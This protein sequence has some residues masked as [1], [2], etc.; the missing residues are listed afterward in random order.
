MQNTTNSS[1]EKL[2]KIL[3]H[4]GYVNPII[5]NRNNTLTL[6][7]NQIEYINTIKQKT[8]CYITE[9]TENYFNITINITYYMNEYYGQNSPTTIENIK[10]EYEFDIYTPQGDEPID[11]VERYQCTLE[12]INI[13]EIHTSI[14]Y[15]KELIKNKS[16]IISISK[17]VY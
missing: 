4:K 13:H 16:K 14:K 15:I 17:I 10:F 2:L 11:L 9:K 6:E 7:I 1:L 3:A 12:N 5:T 8:Y